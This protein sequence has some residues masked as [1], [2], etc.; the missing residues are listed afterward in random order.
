VLL[1]ALVLGLWARGPRRHRG[2]T[3]IAPAEM[4]RLLRRG[5]AYMAGPHAVLMAD[6][7]YYYNPQTG[8]YEHDPQAMDPLLA[9]HWVKQQRRAAFWSGFVWTILLLNWL[10]PRR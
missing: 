9:A 10:R 6:G 7:A 1:V 3:G 8:R 2:P 4:Q 5:G